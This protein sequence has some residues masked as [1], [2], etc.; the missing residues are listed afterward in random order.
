MINITNPIVGT[1][2][3]FREQGYVYG[4]IV[5]QRGYVSRKLTTYACTPVYAVTKGKRKGQLFILIPSYISTRYCRRIYLVRCTADV[6][7][8]NPTVP[9]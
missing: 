4:D 6:L 2:E 7:S 8:A 1:Y 9:Y 3:D 5:W